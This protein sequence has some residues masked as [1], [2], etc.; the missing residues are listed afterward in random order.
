MTIARKI[1]TQRIIVAVVLMT[2]TGFAAGDQTSH[3]NVA[4]AK[5]AV[6]ALPKEFSVEN[7]GLKGKPGDKS[8]ADL[9]QRVYLKSPALPLGAD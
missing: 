8:R 6:D 1:A 4:T 5:A 9:L 3:S 2:V 7:C